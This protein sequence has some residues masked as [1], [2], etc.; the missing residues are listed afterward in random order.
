[1]APSR[2]ASLLEERSSIWK[3][4]AA[5][6]LLCAAVCLAGR[7]VVEA[8]PLG[9]AL[10]ASSGPG[11]RTAAP[12]VTALRGRAAAMQL[13]SLIPG[14][15]LDVVGGKGPALEACKP[16]AKNCWSTASN[17]QEWVWPE[18]TSRSAAIGDL[19]AAIADYPQEGQSGVDKGG[20]TYVSDNLVLGGSARL[21]FLSG[22][23]G[24]LAKLL[25]GG[26]KYV[27]DVEF[28][29]GESSV[30]FRSSSRVGD[31]DFGVN[32]KRMNYIA[33]ILRENGW[34]APNVK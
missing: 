5:S 24:I 28:S 4:R 7:A 16:G 20:W 13:E 12:S 10:V 27:D 31:S 30:A 21:E 9:A 2:T 6:L 29:V 8:V 23:D 14:P 26:E 33:G 34:D 22:G 19:R 1:M 15:L 11:A 25:N 32:A 18:G 3:R 17:A